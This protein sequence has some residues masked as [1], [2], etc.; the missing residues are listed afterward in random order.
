M[1][2]AAKRGEVVTY[3]GEEDLRF[4]RNFHDVFLSLGLII[5]FMG[6]SMVTEIIAATQGLMG[7][8][9]GGIKANLVLRALLSGGLAGL[10][11]MMAEVFSRTRRLVL[12]SMVLFIG[13]SQYVFVA[14]AALYLAFVAGAKDLD[15]LLELLQ[16]VDGFPLYLSVVMTGATFLFYARMKLPFA[17]GALGLCLASFI[18]SFYIMNTDWKAEGSWMAFGEDFRGL[19]IMAGLVL[20]GLGLYFDALD[21]ER[22]SRLSDNGFW[23]HFFA[24]PVL[25][26]GAMMTFSGRGGN[27]VTEGASP[28]LALI[29]VGVFAFVSLLINRRALLVSGL[30]TA[31]FAIS[32][33][34]RDAGIGGLWSPATTMVM[35]GGAM[36]VL[37]GAWHALRA[38]VVAPFPKSGPLARI[39]PP[40]T[41][42]E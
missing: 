13:W 10:A 24:A 23:L 11:W 34:V 28:V 40:V 4:I 17:M 32:S 14:A 18:F 19:W 42:M 27:G 35:L 9:V 26:S 38:I 22:K 21:P 31:A 39:I 33:L 6:L 5:L 30:L 1:A 8:G 41:R 36:V 29:I 3:A 16:T 25:F 12:P 20:F 2:R 37:G 15:Q 7:Q